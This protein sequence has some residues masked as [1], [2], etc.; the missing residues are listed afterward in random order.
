MKAL[1]SKWFGQTYLGLSDK[2]GAPDLSKWNNWGGSL[3]LG[4]PFAATGVR[5]CMHAVSRQVIFY[6]FY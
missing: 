5:L 1:D 6:A 4:H 2:F 3:S